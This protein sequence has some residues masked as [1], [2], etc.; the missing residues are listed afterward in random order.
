[1]HSAFV[2]FLAQLRIHQ[3]DNK[4]FSIKIYFQLT[5][6][7]IKLKMF[8]IPHI[9]MNNKTPTF[10]AITMLSQRTKG[11]SLGFLDGMDNVL[12]PFILLIS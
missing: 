12:V 10:L 4:T 1:M 6:V 11:L 9:I 7:S 2:C 3:D 5:D 8:I